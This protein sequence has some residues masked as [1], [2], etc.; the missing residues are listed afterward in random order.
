M[1]ILQGRP[2]AKPSFW[3]R[4]TRAVGSLDQVS[5]PGWCFLTA[6]G[7]VHSQP[8]PSSCN[9]SSPLR[10]GP[11]LLFCLCALPLSTWSRG[12]Y[13]LETAAP[14]PREALAL[15]RWQFLHPTSSASPHESLPATLEPQKGTGGMTWASKVF[16][17]SLALG[18]LGGIRWRHAALNAVNLLHFMLLLLLFFSKPLSQ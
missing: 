8:L 4:L 2:G 14:L 16:H 12:P 13:R 18:I 1:A 3:V 17:R 15:A 6:W 7:S 10:G 5:G 11:Q 9:Q